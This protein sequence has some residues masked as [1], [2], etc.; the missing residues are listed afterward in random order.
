MAPFSADLPDCGCL[1]DLRH[2]TGKF[3]CQV[4]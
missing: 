1:T 3:K 2:E 4:N